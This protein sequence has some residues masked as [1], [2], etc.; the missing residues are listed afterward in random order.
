MSYDYIYKDVNILIIFYA[1][2]IIITQIF[3][4]EKHAD[5][6]H[7]HSGHYEQKGKDDP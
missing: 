7:A 5:I 3:A 1:G 4:E 2:D 6:G